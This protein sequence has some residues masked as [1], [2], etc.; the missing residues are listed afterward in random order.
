MSVYFR[1]A[2]AWTRCFDA[3]VCSGRVRESGGQWLSDCN[4]CAAVKSVPTPTSY[5]P[6][7]HSKSRQSAVFAFLSGLSEAKVS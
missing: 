2:L 7:G 6:D 5:H 1:Q 3:S 4:H